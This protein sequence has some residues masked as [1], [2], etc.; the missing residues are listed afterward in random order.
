MK[1]IDTLI[2]HA[3][4]FTMRGQGVGYVEDGCVA[5]DKGKIIEVGK[6]ADLINEYD[7]TEL[8]HAADKM[9]LPGF[10]DA[11]IHTSMSM[12][13]GVA[14][15]TKHWMLK[16]VQPLK[17]YLKPE[18]CPEASYVN[19]LEA[20]ASGTTT[21]GEYAS[22]EHLSQ[23]E[24]FL[25]KLGARS[26][27][28]VVV[29]GWNKQKKAYAVDDL[30]E[31]DD[32]YTRLSLQKNIDLFYKWD[33]PDSR[34]TVMLGIHAPDTLSRE[35]LLECRDAAVKH[36]MRIHMHVAQGDRETTQMLKRYGKRSIPFLDELGY[37]DSRLLAV[38]LTDATDDEARLV[39]AKGASMVLCAGSIGICDGIMPPAHVFQ[40]AGGKVA[41][42]SD[43]NAGNNCNQIINEMKLTAMYNKIKYR[44][45]AVMPAWKA[46]RMAT[47]EGAQAIGLDHRIGSIEKG[48]C[49]D[50][51]FVDLMTPT[52]MPVIKKPFRNHVPNLVY[53]A[54]GSEV[55]QVMVNG[56]T[57]YK[58]GVFTTVDYPY[59]LHEFKAKSQRFFEETPWDMEALQTSTG[60]LLQQNEQ[61]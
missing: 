50:I 37:L 13:R 61:L 16:G 48:K 19:V 49:A 38:H 40:T 18:S 23:M 8:I 52:M 20:L 2:I 21:F 10:I 35:M 4:L 28:A 51:I 60:W 14:Q 27:L 42:G 39:A 58:N 30:F 17:Y 45:P 11:H 41:L 33:K 7:P 5:I 57:L 47:I 25:D 1:R 29:Y 59:L 53:S 54:R 32:N 56:R 26:N 24:V 6:T 9:V 31:L 55:C 15:D 36:N 3:D 46:L 34:T 22:F 44:D 43:Q 12:F